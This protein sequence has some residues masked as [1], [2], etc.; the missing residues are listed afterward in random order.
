MRLNVRQDGEVAVLSL[1]GNLMGR[2]ENHEIRERLQGLKSKGIS[3]L[4]VDLGKV[5]HI[6]SSCLGSLVGGVMTMRG[7]GGDVKLANLSDRAERIIEIVQLG[8]VVDIFDTVDQA[9][10]SYSVVHA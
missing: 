1:S 8:R 7:I 9:I 5:T 6:N 4:V 3:R 2:S 10:A